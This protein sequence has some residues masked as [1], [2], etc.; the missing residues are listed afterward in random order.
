M[1][2]G[3]SWTEQWL[4]FDNSYFAVPDGPDGEQ[5]LRL[6]TDACLAK[7]P[8]FKPFFDRYAASQDDFFKDCEEKAGAAYGALRGHGRVEGG[9]GMFCHVAGADESSRRSRW[10]CR[11]HAFEGPR[12]F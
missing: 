10:C 9:R 7:D 2:G 12:P 6:E 5:L 3:Q 11:W 8:A 4:K 1:A